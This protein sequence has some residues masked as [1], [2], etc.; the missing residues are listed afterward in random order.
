[1]AKPEWGRYTQKDNILYAHWMNQN[2][3]DINA[4][5]LKYSNVKNVFLLSSGA[6]LSYNK[7]WW[8]NE[9]QG[10]FFINVNSKSE[11]P[12]YLDTVLKIEMKK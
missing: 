2:L 7:T 1:M 10:N 11:K 3:G 6:E 4:K 12:D 9:E 5:G 8:G